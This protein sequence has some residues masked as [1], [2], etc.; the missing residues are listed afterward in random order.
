[1]ERHLKFQS[2]FL[3]LAY[4][5]DFSCGLSKALLL[6]LDF[7]IKLQ[8]WGTGIGTRVRGQLMHKSD[9]SQ[10]FGIINRI[11]EYLAFSWTV[12]MRQENKFS[13]G[14]FIL[15]GLYSNPA[16]PACLLWSGKWEPAW[17]AKWT[18]TWHFLLCIAEDDSGVAEPASL[19]RKGVTWKEHPSFWIEPG[20][21]H[22]DFPNAN[23]PWL[24]LS[25]GQLW[26]LISGFL[27]VLFFFLRL[28]V[29]L[30]S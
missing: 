18:Q 17:F 23:S 6:D 15:T 3:Y 27:E 19:L 14:L 8:Q 1:M 29:S 2:I 30:K 22:L 16:F 26:L 13:E 21:V 25:Q 10:I 11:R 4:S 28:F 5:W 9:F 24:W 20:P 12:L 7:I